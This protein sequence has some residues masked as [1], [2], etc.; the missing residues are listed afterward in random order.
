MAATE[1]TLRPAT[2][3]DAPA[4]AEYHLRA[5]KASFAE[6][7]ISGSYD[8]ATPRVERF[9]SWLEP[10]SGF[11]TTV[12]DI[13]G[14]AVGHVTVSG[15]ELV[16]LFI[17]PD[18][19][20]RGLGRRLLAAGEELLATAGHTDVE[21]HTMIGNTT[22]IALYRSA[23]WTVTDVV[24]DNDHDGVTYREHVLVKRLPRPETA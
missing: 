9:R 23:G 15:N 19:Q 18:H 14:V 4:I 12:A 24:I 16:H 1:P 7:L 20:G 11:T 6:L 22:A 13:D 17:D 2:V 21:L 5:S 8:G 10:Q 3:D